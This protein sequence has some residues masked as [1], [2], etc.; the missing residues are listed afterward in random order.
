MSVSVIIQQLAHSRERVAAQIF[1][2][3]P[4]QAGP[5]PNEEGP[6]Q[7]SQTSP[8][9]ALRVTAT[10]IAAAIV[11]F[12]YDV[13]SSSGHHCARPEV[14]RSYDPSILPV[15]TCTREYLLSYHL[16]L[17]DATRNDD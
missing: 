7:T 16:V 10:A 15:A 14:I 5:V 13:V 8:A 1:P 9:A 12:E 6:L 4:W 2:P 11:L 3:I 17:T